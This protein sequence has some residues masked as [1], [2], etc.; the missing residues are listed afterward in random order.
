MRT[1]ETK[2]FKFNE[3]AAEGKERALEN[4]RNSESFTFEEEYI[5]SIRELA[6][7]FGGRVKNYEIDFSGG[8]CHSSMEFDMPEM[9]EHEIN[10]IFETLG[11]YNADTLKGLGDCVLTGYCTDEDAI[12][13]FRKAFLGGELDL[14]KL[15]QAAFKTWFE[16][17]QDDYRAQYEEENYAELC[18]ANNCEFTEDG[19]MYRG[20]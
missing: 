6:N 5:G 2:I 20:K 9:E 13:G 15:M 16:A 12:D 11:Q 1:I 10:G 14:N 19:E 18:D 3:L 4:Y 17:A 8:F 7:R